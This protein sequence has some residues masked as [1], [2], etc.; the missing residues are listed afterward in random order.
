MEQRPIFSWPRA[1]DCITR[2]IYCN[3]SVEE[4]NIRIPEATALISV[5]FSCSY[6]LVF[7]RL[8]LGLPLSSPPIV[9]VLYDNCSYFSKMAHTEPALTWE[10]GYATRA[11]VAAWEK[12]SSY[13]N[14]DGESSNYLPPVSQELPTS[15]MHNG[16][17]E[18]KNL[19]RTWPSLY[20]GTQA[21]EIPSWWNPQPEVDVL[22][23]GGK[24]A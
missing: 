7:A 19:L 6:L 1:I 14:E 21:Q 8:C 13:L 22:I 15:T 2:A 18:T 5:L 10:R 3:E 9:P 24:G 12:E 23:S 16:V 20:N 11:G 17:T 4:R